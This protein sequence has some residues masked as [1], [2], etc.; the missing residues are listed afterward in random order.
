M[1]IA[2]AILL[3]PVTWLI[4]EVRSTQMLTDLDIIG[5]GE[6][7]VVQIH[8]P[9]FEDSERLRRDIDAARSRMSGELA[10]RVV[11]IDTSR[12]ARFAYEYG[13]SPATVMLFDARGEVAR[14]IEGGGSAEDLE[15]TFTAHLRGAK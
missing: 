8:E 1:V 13:V 15:A 11:N 3:V 12:G 14:V 4:M 7:V 9:G 10:F 2:L 5:S 6:P